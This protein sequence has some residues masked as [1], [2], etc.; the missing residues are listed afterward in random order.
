[1]GDQTRYRKYE[2]YD[3][4]SK[5]I[6]P[7]AGAGSCDEGPSLPAIPSFYAGPEAMKAPADPKPV[8]NRQPNVPAGWYPD[9]ARRHQQRFWDG[10]IWTQQVADNGTVGLDGGPSAA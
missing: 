10:S 5:P 8:V 3:F 4:V 2:V 1:M 9:P 6:G 7:L